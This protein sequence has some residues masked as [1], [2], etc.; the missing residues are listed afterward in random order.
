MNTMANNKT[1]EQLIQEQKAFSANVGKRVNAHTDKKAQDVKTF[2][3]AAGG[4][5]NKCDGQWVPLPCHAIE[6]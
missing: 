2:V 5:A 1:L 4:R 3:A 6:A